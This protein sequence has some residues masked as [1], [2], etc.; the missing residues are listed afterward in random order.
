MLIE[1]V[2]SQLPLGKLM[3][4]ATAR[5]MLTEYCRKDIE[6]LLH[7]FQGRASLRS[8]L[9]ACV[10]LRI[11]T[12]YHK[13][14]AEQTGQY[15]P[16]KREQERATRREARRHERAQVFK[17]HEQYL[18]ALPSLNQR[19]VFA[20]YY[21]DG[22]PLKWIAEFMDLKPDRVRQLRHRAMERMARLA[23]VGGST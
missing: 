1:D 23:V 21:R 10:Q 13:L 17:K 8:Y 4:C 22:R 11:R 5:L 7:A 9:S 14:R 2:V 15:I 18:D 12:V 19:A 16:T 20:L 6:K 3:S